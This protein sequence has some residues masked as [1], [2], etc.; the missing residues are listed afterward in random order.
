MRFVINHAG[1]RIVDATPEE[2]HALRPCICAALRRHGCPEREIDDIAQH[3]EI[4][5]WQGIQD[6]RIQGYELDEPDVALLRFMFLVAKNAFMNYKRKASTRYEAFQ[7]E[8]AEWPSCSPV[9]RLEARDLL[10]RIEERPL[11]A[12]FL[13]NV[14]AEVP[15]VERYHDAQMGDGTYNARLARSRKWLRSVVTSGRWREPPQPTPPTPWHRKK[16]R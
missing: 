3:V 4:V 7:D 11:V 9:A 12:R 10:R 13:L 6:G 5:T 14:A 15:Y 16:R 8:P 2:T 1:N